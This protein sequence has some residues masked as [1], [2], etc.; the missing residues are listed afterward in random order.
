[1]RLDEGSH[2]DHQSLPALSLAEL[3]H[4]F[5]YSTVAMDDVTRFSLEEKAPAEKGR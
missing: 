5:K 1:M 3:A 2:C 4:P